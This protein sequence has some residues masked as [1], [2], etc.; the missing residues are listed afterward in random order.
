MS[1]FRPPECS[2]EH[3]AAVAHET[4][5]PSSLVSRIA[6]PHELLRLSRH[7]VPAVAHHLQ[8]AFPRR[9]DADSMTGELVFSR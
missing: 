5:G 9:L 3:D 8:R 1:S 7:V 4:D 6:D 2:I